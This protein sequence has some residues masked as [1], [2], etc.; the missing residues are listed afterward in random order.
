MT[1][2]VTPKY[3][4]SPARPQAKPA[5]VR[6]LGRHVDVGLPIPHEVAAWICDVLL[7]AFANVYQVNAKRRALL[8]RLS[9]VE[10][11]R[12]FEIRENMARC[13]RIGRDAAAEVHD[14]TT[15]G[16][17]EYDV[18]REIALRHGL[19][20]GVLMAFM[21]DARKAVRQRR[22]EARAIE[23]L[24]L[25]RAGRNN[26]EIGRQLGITAQHAGRLLRKAHSQFPGAA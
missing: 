1:A 24:E 20:I 3:T 26:A 9:D 15:R 21:R 19:P 13:E 2:G 22:D 14:R 18:A 5:T 7:P 10:A 11:Q 12:Q 23:V 8:E 16:E 25:H 17:R 4:L 6:A